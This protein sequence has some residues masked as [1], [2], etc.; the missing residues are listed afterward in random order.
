MR[1]FFSLISVFLFSV[2][3]AFAVK[4][5]TIPGT[6]IALIPP[7]GFRLAQD[8]T[9]FVNDKTKASIFVVIFPEETANAIENIYNNRK[10][11]M[12]IMRDY[13]F[14]IENHLNEK[15][16][17]GEAITIY[18]G[19]QSDNETVY[20]KWATVISH[21]G[22]Y[23]VTLQSPKQANLAPQTA[24]AF[25][26]SIKLGAWNSLE[27][28]A[29]ALP[30]I[31]KAIP[32]FTVRATLMGSAITLQAD[33]KKGQNTDPVSIYI[34]RDTQISSSDSVQPV[35]K[36]YLASIRQAFE[37]K[38]ITEE[39]KIPFAGKEGKLLV[40]TG[41]DAKGK[42]ESIILYS[43]IDDTGRAIHLQAT[44]TENALSS[45]K[46]TIGKIAASIRLKSKN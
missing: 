1:F 37:L 4:W 32:P 6:P 11:F 24:I 42:S 41:F 20:D 22:I 30:F 40:G 23:M 16:E 21:N 15:I 44:G 31:F 25:F 14:I 34:I 29:S 26:R 10:E 35:Q 17:T 36:L 7:P 38:K 2:N 43:A 28:Q 33:E 13:K 46:E 3:T 9:G 18:F 45:L 8:F 19:T 12:K 39:K 5:Q 27:V